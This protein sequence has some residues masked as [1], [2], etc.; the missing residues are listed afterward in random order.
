M[1]GGTDGSALSEKVRAASA[2]ALS[3]FRSAAERSFLRRPCRNHSICRP[4]ENMP[5]ERA[6]EA[7]S[8]GGQMVKKMIES[9]EKNL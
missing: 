3:V 9:Y 6:R 2:R 7:G 8:V 5:P 4:A 1:R